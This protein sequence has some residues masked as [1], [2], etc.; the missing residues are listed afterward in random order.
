MTAEQ[1]PEPEFMALMKRP[2]A[3]LPVAMSLAALAAVLGQLSVFGVVRAADEGAAAHL[4][5]LLIVGQAPLV[6]YF[7]LQWVPR[8]P[9]HALQVLAVQLAAVLVALAP[10]FFFRL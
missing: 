6:A 3:Y 8:A 10:V 1:M 2:S 9:R 4:F 5:Q 7:A